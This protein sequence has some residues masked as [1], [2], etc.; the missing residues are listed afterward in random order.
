MQQGADG[1]L[2]EP[3]MDL[4]GETFTFPLLEFQALPREFLLQ[5][6]SVMSRFA[7][8]NVLHRDD[9]TRDFAGR[10]LEQCHDT[11]CPTNLSR[12]PLCSPPI[13]PW[14]WMTRRCSHRR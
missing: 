2:H 8:R 13:A 10:I 7:F 14:N 5:Q 11:R 4:V 12:A 6:E 1:I 9:L 3:V